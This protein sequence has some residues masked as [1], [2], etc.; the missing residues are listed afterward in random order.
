MSRFVP[1]RFDIEFDFDS[2][3]TGS[4]APTLAARLRYIAFSSSRYF[5]DVAAACLGDEVG[6]ARTGLS[7]SVLSSNEASLTR[8]SETPDRLVGAR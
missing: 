5:T 4:G 3:E 6:L 8:K 1:D 2:V 7:N